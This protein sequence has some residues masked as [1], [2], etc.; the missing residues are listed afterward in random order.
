MTVAEESHDGPYQT[1]RQAAAASSWARDGRPSGEMSGHN[2]RDLLDACT[3]ARVMVG[4][5][6]VTV[7]EW[8]AGYEPSTVAV[9][10]GLITRAFEAGLDDPEAG[11]VLHGGGWISGTSGQQPL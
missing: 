10:T 2:L 9:I 7:L 8:L 5:H 11:K 6:D 1:E 4:K 3:E